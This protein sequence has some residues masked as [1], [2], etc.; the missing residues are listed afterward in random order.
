MEAPK[1]TIA[2]YRN[3]KHNYTTMQEVDGYTANDSD[4]VRISEPA[5]VKFIPINATQVQEKMIQNTLDTLTRVNQE[6]EERVNDLNTKLFELRA[7][8]APTDTEVAA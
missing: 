8:T 3:V 1:L 6:H 4:F 2:L 7:L 5:E